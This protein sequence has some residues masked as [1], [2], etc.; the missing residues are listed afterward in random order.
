M[1][2]NNTE[3]KL[4]KSNKNKMLDGVCG[5]IGE[6]FNID[7]TLVR[8][9]CVA[10]C[11]FGGGGLLAYIVALI[12]IPRAPEGYDPQAANTNTAAGNASTASTAATSSE[13]CK[14]AEDTAPPTDNDNT[15]TML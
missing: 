15:P 14:P 3:K 7:P 9:A 8:L 2:T 10:L 12:I 5:G 1:D 11:I 4:Y 13:P 6:Y